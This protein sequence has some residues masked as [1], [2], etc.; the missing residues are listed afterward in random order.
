MKIFVFQSTLP[1]QGE[2]ITKVQCMK[3]PKFQSTLPI[4]GET[5]IQGIPLDTRA[6]QSTLPIQGETS[7]AN[8]IL[9]ITVEFQSTLPIQGETR[10]SMY[11][12]K[13]WRISIHSPYTGRDK[14][15]LKHR[16]LWED[17]NPLSLY[18]ERRRHMIL[19]LKCS[20]HFN[21]LSLYRER[22][23]PLC[24]SCDQVRFQSTLPIQGETYLRQESKSSWSDFNPLSLYRERLRLWKFLIYYRHFNPLSLYRERLFQLCSNR[25]RIYFNPLSL[26]RERPFPPSSAN[27]CRLFQSTLP[28]QGETK[29][30]WCLRTWWNIFQSTLPIQGETCRI[31]DW[32]HEVGNFNPLS[33]YRERHR[34]MSRY[35]IQEE[36]QSTLPIQGETAIL[37]IK[38]LIYSQSLM[39]NAKQKNFF[40]HLHNKL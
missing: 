31:H 30:T 26:Y 15:K 36:F 2:T 37:H 39:Q 33:L 7:T 19:R 22:L 25:R 10:R 11:G 1:I 4:Q 38:L 21:P 17:F 28:I 20:S 34:D 23:C 9:L 8:C 40:Q 14:W 13:K 6:F 18:R 16:V 3:L 29:N 27:N 24:I 12:A 32:G 5:K 35:T